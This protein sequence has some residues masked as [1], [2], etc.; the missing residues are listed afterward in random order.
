M[1][2]Y[3]KSEID[4]KF[5]VTISSPSWRDLYTKTEIETNVGTPETLVLP[6]NML[7]FYTKTEVDSILTGSLMPC[8]DGVTNYYDCKIGL[9]TAAWENQIDGGNDATF[10][11]MEIQTDGAA[12][13]MGTNASY[14]KFVSEYTQNRTIYAVFRAPILGKI[15]LNRHVIGS[16]GGNINRFRTGAWFSISI[17]GYGGY[18]HITT[19]QWGIGTGSQ[20]NCGDYHVATVTRSGNTN[21]LYVDGAL[22][23][24]LAN[25]VAYSNNWGIGLIIDD[26]DQLG[27]SPSSLQQIK[28]IA[29]GNTAHTADQVARNSAWL[30]RYYELD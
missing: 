22:I 3:T 4:E 17:D 20:I 12:G 26:F 24:T 21:T 28:M 14:G 7:D 30:R 2:F 29:V 5:G 8:M 25:A 1:D 10:V 19:D 23:G 13:V 11:G 15:N 27:V 16:C 9:T 18:D 6:A